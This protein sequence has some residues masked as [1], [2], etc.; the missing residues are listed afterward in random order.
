MFMT[1]GLILG[2]VQGILGMGAADQQAAQANMQARAALAEKRAAHQW[3]TMQ[4]IFKNIQDNYQISEQKKA[5][6]RQNRAIAAAANQTAAYKKVGLR[7]QE[8]AALIQLKEDKRK[9]LIV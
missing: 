4:G 1:A 8:K 9:L 3:Q 6:L 7:E 5:R 2:G